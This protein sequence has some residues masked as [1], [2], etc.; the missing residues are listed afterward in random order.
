M[1]AG[2]GCEAEG[3]AGER[4]GTL[5]ACESVIYTGEQSGGLYNGERVR[6]WGAGIV[7]EMLAGVWGVFGFCSV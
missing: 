7:G 6:V 3:R 4:G 2:G 5:G 1:R